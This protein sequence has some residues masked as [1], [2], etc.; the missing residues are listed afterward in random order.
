MKKL[1]SLLSLLSCL[2]IIVP[3]IRQRLIGRVEDIVEVA[4][5]RTGTSIGSSGRLMT[6][7]FVGSL[8][9]R[10]CAITGAG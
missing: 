2:T 7:S 4:G 3:P 10:A 8:T 6:T 9:R 5:R 1:I